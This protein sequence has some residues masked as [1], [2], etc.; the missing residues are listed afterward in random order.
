[1]N[2][3]FVRTAMPLIGLDL[4]RP[5][6][7]I[8]SAPGHWR[9]RIETLRAEDRTPECRG[10]LESAPEHY[11]RHDVFDQVLY[12]PRGWP[13]RRA[14]RRASRARRYPRPITKLLEVP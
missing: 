10:K 9:G 4:I 2:T 3:N 1:M 5:N 7:R 12:I 6:G 8:E 13:L 14:V 11:E